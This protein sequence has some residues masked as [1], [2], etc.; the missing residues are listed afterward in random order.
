MNRFLF[1]K[2]FLIIALLLVLPFVSSIVNAITFDDLVLE[3]KKLLGTEKNAKNFTGNSI[4]EITSDIALTENGDV[5]KNGEM[6]GGD[7]VRFSFTISNGTDEPY[8]F[9][10]LKTNI[11]RDSI[12]FI[13][14]I[15]GVTGIDNDTLEL[16]NVYVS[17]KSKVEISFDAVLNYSK[18]ESLVEGAAARPAGIAVEKE[19]SSQPML[20]DSKKKKLAEGIKTVKKF[21]PAAIKN[22]SVSKQRNNENASPVSVS[23]MTGLA[24]SS[25]S[26]QEAAGKE[27][28]PASELI[29]NKTASPSASE[30]TNENSN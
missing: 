18:E 7:T 12:H 8:P 6:D 23:V 15:K 26:A 19:I 13:H 4:I 30:A 16:P 11:K 24:A 29:E 14:N 17:P 21:K 28:S 22:G 3:G 25:P 10:N 20:E 5:N 2:I 9:S 1:L 27:A